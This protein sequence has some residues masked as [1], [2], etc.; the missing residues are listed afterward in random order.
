VLSL[1]WFGW[2]Q[3]HHPKPLVRLNTLTNKTFQVGLALY[4][5]YYYETTAYSYLISR[6]LEGGLGYP[7]ENAG[8]LV[9]VMSLISASA[10]FIY[11][12]YSPLIKHK[13]WII[14]PGFALAAFAAAWMTRTT[15]DISESWLVAPLLMRGLLL[16]FIVVPVANLT[17]R[18]FAVEEFTHVYRLKNI[19]RQLTFSFATASVII[20]EQHRLA[21]HATRLTEAAN[22]FNPAFQSTFAILERAFTH[23]GHSA[24]D[25]Q[26]LALV[27]INAMIARQASFLSSIDGFYFLIGIALC[28]GLFAAWQKQID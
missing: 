10:L 6:F 4:V 7:V 26:T 2:H 17:F 15:P 25:A 24:A 9:G 1:G 3:W 18:I 21:L 14:V 27:Q 23:L 5:F 12:R 19:V 11:F 28:G 22:P 16:L 8:R 20:L 13:K